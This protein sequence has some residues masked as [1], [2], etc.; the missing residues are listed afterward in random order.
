[1]NGAY[2][3]G[4]V[5]L[6]A[7][8]RALETI[9]NNVANVNTA[10]FKREDVR[11]AEVMAVRPQP[12]TETE[13]QALEVSSPAGGVRMVSRS[14]YSE[15]GELRPTASEMDIAIDGRGFIELMAPRGESYLWRGGRLGINRDGYLSVEGGLPLR[16]L[17]AVPDDITELR[18]DPDGVVIG[19]AEAGNAV[20]LGQIMLVRTETDA[21]LVRA[22][23]GLFKTVENARIIEAVPG[24]DGSG[25]IAQKMI[26]GSNVD[27]AS[28]MV[29]M[30][31]LQRAYAASAQVIQAAD[32]L[33]AV[34][35]NLQR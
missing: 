4:A 14:M 31:V 27:M 22:G 2:E 25:K 23:D 5:A 26:E 12:N 7:Q 9:A 3:V 20:E 17:I 35:N 10:G 18:I 11:F 29:E 16:S 30:L 6:R 28:S 32:Q 34:A 21:D 15:T 33:S 13:R 8:Q 19:R 24:E 1:M